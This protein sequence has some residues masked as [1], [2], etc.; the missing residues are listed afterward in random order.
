[1]TIIKGQQPATAPSFDPD[2][3]LFPEWT[4]AEVFANDIAMLMGLTMGLPAGPVKSAEERRHAASNAEICIGQ[5]LETDA[6]ASE[7][8]LLSTTSTSAM[9]FMNLSWLMMGRLEKMLENGILTEEL[10]GNA[11]KAYYR[12]TATLGVGLHDVF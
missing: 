12:L 4:P 2:Y 3:R 1:M 6:R 7:A 11:R 5:F 10:W 8:G 9:I